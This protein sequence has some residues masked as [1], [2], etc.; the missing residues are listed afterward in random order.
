VD[1][2]A[3]IGDNSDNIPGVPG[4]GP[5]SAVEIICTLGNVED[6]I[7]APETLDAENK[8]VKKILPHLELLQRNREL[9]RLRTEL[10]EAFCNDLP[11]VRR[12]P[13]WREIRK[14]CEDNQFKSLLKELPDVPE[15]IAEE[16]SFVAGDEDDLFT[17]AAHAETAEKVEK[18][19]KNEENEI[20]GELF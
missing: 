12:K 20:Q 16:P 7:N 1:Y 17:F 15:I 5:K 11:P 18:K 8:Y 19:P 2:L 14:I 10:P 6:W 9:I 3:L 4:I 13:D